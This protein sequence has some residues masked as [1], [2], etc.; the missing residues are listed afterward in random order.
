MDLRKGEV[1]SGVIFIRER[2]EGRGWMIVGGAGR[3]GNEARV[4]S[5]IGVREPV[6][7]VEISG[8]AWKVG[9]EW[10]VLES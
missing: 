3:E 10:K 2:G 8:E 6:W 4:G 7:E 9:V 5:K 1:G